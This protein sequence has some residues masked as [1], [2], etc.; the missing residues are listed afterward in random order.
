M[1]A[2]RN[3]RLAVVIEPDFEETVLLRNKIITPIGEDVPD[4]GIS[5]F[6]Q[7][8]AYVQNKVNSIIELTESALS[9][10]TIKVFL[11]DI[12]ISLADILSDFLQ[13]YTLFNLPGKRKYGIASLAINWIPGKMKFPFCHKTTIL[14][15]E[16]VTGHFY[17]GGIES[18]FISV[19]F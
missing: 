11:W 2:S 6:R 19:N 7:S 4:A 16:W 1:A 5:R 3:N 17:F 18:G 8:I 13:G 12:I 10:I 15:F 14:A 9:F